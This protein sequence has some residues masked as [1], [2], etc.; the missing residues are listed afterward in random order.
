[1]RVL[2]LIGLLAAGCYDP[3]QPECRLRCSTEGICP[4]GSA[5]G[6]DGYCHLPNTT[7][8][9]DDAG[10]PDMGPDLSEP[11]DLRPEVDT[12]PPT[13]AGAKTA[14]PGTAG[15]IIVTWEAGSDDKTPTEELLYYVYVAV[16]PG[17]QDFGTPR[18]ITPPGATQHTLTGLLPATTYYVVVRARDLAGLAD[19][20]TI[21]V[22]ARTPLM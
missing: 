17:A 2:V 1:M 10:L 12:Q 8:C 5:C 18:F 7:L 22:S 3:D 13:F 6:T 14:M 21:E 19:A 20:N 11:P 15:Q 4:I 9:P 16:T